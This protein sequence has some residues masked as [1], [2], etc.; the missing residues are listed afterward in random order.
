M[1]PPVPENVPCS[2]LTASFTD[3][4]GTTK[5]RWVVDAPVLVVLSVLRANA[6]F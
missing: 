1:A 4:S 6:R 2:S 5:V 3:S